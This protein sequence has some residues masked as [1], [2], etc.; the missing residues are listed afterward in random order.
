VIYPAAL[1]EVA[2]RV[3]AMLPD[4]FQS[5][6]QA[7]V[8]GSP[9]ALQPVGRAGPRSALSSGAV[10]VIPIYGPLSHRETLFAMI[11]G[12]SS[13]QRLSASLR[14][15][16]ADPNISSIIFDIDSPGGVVDG[17]PELSSEIFNARGK[18]RMVAVCNS[19]A[20]SAAYW[21]ATSAD[22]VVVSPSGQ[23]GSIGVFAAH[24]DISKALEDEGVKVTLISAGK[25]KTEGTPFKPLSPEARA[26][27]QR[28]VDDF[29]AMFVAAVARNRGVATSTVKHGFGEG[30]MLLA[31]DAARAGMVDGVATLDQTLARLLGRH[32]SKGLSAVERSLR[33][34]ELELLM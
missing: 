25:Y 20:A 8:H 3:M 6:I 28:M 24:E 21:L 17:I 31:Q 4:T 9:G 10:S 13:T 34:R 15:A 27:M 33:R 12:G 2:D 23:V 11:F 19:M 29:H 14:Q 22:E 5:M 1:Y 26:N 7:L 16:L 30:R 18:K 32:T